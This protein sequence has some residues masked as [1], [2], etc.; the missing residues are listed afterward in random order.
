MVAPSPGAANGSRP[1]QCSGRPPT[2]ACLRTR[3]CTSA[4]SLPPAAGVRPRTAC[5]IP[6]MSIHPGILGCAG[7][8]RR[9]ESFRCAARSQTDRPAGSAPRLPES[10]VPD[11]NPARRHLRALVHPCQWLQRKAGARQRFAQDARCGTP[12][13]RIDAVARWGRPIRRQYPLQF[14]LLR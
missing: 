12:G 6:G 14:G 2:R 5:R 11:R 10:P 9:G 3:P 8:D 13:P 1:R 4:D 7:I